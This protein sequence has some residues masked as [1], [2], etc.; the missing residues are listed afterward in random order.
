MFLPQTED[1]CHHSTDHPGSGWWFSSSCL[2]VG[3]PYSTHKLLSSKCSSIIPQ[4]SGLHS[5]T[6]PHKKSP[7][8]K[9]L[10]LYQH[11]TPARSLW[12]DRTLPVWPADLHQLTQSLPSFVSVNHVYLWIILV[13]IFRTCWLG[14]WICLHWPLVVTSP[15]TV[16]NPLHRTLKLI[17]VCQR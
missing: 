14:Q 11:W 8:Y 7:P 13:S 2:W 15:K 1:S 9:F 3:H 6:Q 17:T 16:A 10:R 12:L 4:C 5:T